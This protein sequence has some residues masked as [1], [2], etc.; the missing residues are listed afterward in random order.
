MSSKYISSIVNTATKTQIEVRLQ[1][2]IL[3]AFLYSTKPIK[4]EQRRRTCQLPWH[5]IRG[6]L[7]EIMLLKE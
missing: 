2:D 4:E 7:D 3:I 6:V 5:I 1:D